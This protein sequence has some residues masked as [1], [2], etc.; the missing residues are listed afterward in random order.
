MSVKQAIDATMLISDIL[1]EFPKARVVL[2]RFGLNGCGGVHGSAESL[3]YFA[4]KHGLNEVRLVSAL[5]LVAEV[6]EG[7][8]VVRD[9]GEGRVVG[10]IFIVFILR[11]R[12]FLFCLRVRVGVHG[13]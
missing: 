5:N 12:S 8:G 1:L 3:G 2:D 7:L 10:P 11:R 6:G 13:Y 9:Y 4:K